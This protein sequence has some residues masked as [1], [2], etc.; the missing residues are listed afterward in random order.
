MLSAAL[1]A[2]SM[3]FFPQAVC[4]SV[5]M[6]REYIWRPK[7][8]HQLKHGLQQTEIRAEKKAALTE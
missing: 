5:G 1:R 7:T 2:K 4:F 6:M 3:V 8:H